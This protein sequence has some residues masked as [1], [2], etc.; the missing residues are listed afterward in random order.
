MPN[1]PNSP[2]AYPGAGSPA[3]SAAPPAYGIEAW[4]VSD[5]RRFQAAERASGP[6]WRAG[7]PSSLAGVPAPS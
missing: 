2:H 7:N 6:G 4:G 5:V 1:G 3:R